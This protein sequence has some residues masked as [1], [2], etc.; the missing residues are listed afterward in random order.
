MEGW[1]ASRQADPFQAT[2]RR[3][4]RQVRRVDCRLA[5]E[6]RRCSMTASGERCGV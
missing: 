4:D 6:S 5:V 1:G 2:A 3:L